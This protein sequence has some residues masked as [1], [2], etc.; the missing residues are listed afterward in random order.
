MATVNGH[1]P[2]Q[3]TLDGERVPLIRTHPEDRWQAELDSWDDA[4]GELAA[5][6]RAAQ[7]AR[8]GYDAALARVE[9]AR[10]RCDFARMAT[11]LAGRA[12]GN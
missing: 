7:A 8:A 10:R 4:L 6:L 9:V 12:R 2:A 5:A 11:V 1:T 3:F